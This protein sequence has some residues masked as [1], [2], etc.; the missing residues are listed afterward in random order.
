MANPNN[1]VSEEKLL[2]LPGKVVNKFKGRE[3][4]IKAMPKYGNL[5][6]IP[7]VKTPSNPKITISIISSKFKK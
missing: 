4:S 1:D 3:A 5:I 6:I 7:N 2:R